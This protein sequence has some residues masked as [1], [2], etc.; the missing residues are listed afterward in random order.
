MTESMKVST[1]TAARKSSSS[2]TPTVPLE[3]IF[4]TFLRITENLVRVTDLGKDDCGTLL[5]LFRR[6]FVRMMLQGQL[7]VRLF[8]F[9]S[10]RLDGHLQQLVRIVSVFHDGGEF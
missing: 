8:Y 1:E 6:L 10:G 4:T 9:I 3:V 2:T 5:G 7:A